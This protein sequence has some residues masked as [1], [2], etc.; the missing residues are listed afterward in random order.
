MTVDVKLLDW[1]DALQAPSV[2]GGKAYQLAQ[3]SHYGLPVPAGM[4]IPAEW[5]Q[6]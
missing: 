2:V 5:S 1:T 3:L 4:I 6:R